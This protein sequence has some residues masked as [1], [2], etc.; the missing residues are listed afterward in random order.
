M[1][2][3]QVVGQLSPEELTGLK[4]YLTGQA[5]DGVGEG[6]EQQAIRVDGG[7]LY[8]HMWQPEG[9]SIQDG[10]QSSSG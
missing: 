9:W 4:D 6:L 2:E 7:E 10:G 3:C 8:V 1:A 5:A